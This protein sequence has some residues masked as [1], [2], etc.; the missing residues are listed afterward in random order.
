MADI[1]GKL[2]SYERV[3]DI[4]KAIEED[5]AVKQDALRVTGLESTSLCAGN[6]IEVV[7]VP[8]YVSDVSKYSAYG[9]T[10]AGW[11]S[12]ARI[13]APDGNTTTGVTVA[14]AAGYV[15]GSN[16]VDVALLFGLT[17]ETQV[18]TVKWSNATESYTFKANDLAVRN[19]DYRTTFYVYDIL[20]YATITDDL[21]TFSGM[22]TNVTYKYDAELDRP[23]N[24]VLP[25]VAEDDGHGN[26]I[27]IQ[28][29]YTTA[30][31]VTFTAADDA[32]IVA[33]TGSPRM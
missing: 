4:A 5:I 11:Y 7:G 6:V 13:T 21:I 33:N 31:S 22:P 8:E 19:L 9:I 17:A 20:P 25:E 32:A 12:F 26:W 24:V 2:A 10:E 15:A 16:Y 29:S 18:V 3:R 27:E 23:L 28:I 1:G 30:Y 14:G